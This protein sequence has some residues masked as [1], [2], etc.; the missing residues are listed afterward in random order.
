VSSL[1]PLLEFSSFDRLESSLLD[2]LL[3]SVSLSQSESESES[4]SK[5]SVSK[6]VV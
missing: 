2:P 4:E 6:S 3:E 1:D 5:L